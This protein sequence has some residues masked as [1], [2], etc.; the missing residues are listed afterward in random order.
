MVMPESSLIKTGISGLDSLFLGGIP[1]ANVILVQ[2]VTGCG[3]TLL[4]VEFVYRGILEYGEPGLI[5]VFETS[6]DKLI[7]DGAKFGWNLNEMQ[8]QKKLQIIF[9][10]PQ[11]FHQELRSSDSLLLETAAE[12][13]ARRIFVDGIGLLSTGL[14]NDDSLR[15]NFRGLLQQLMESFNRENLTAVISLETGVSAD[16]VA[17]TEM[18]DFLADTVIQLDRER[19][20]RRMRRSL[21]ILKSR[22]QD[23]DAGEHTLQIKTDHGLQI[24]RRVQAPLRGYLEQPTSGV[25][26][27]FT[28]VEAI[29]TL[30]GGGIF[31][32]S[33]TM[34]VGVSGVGKTVLGTQ[35]LREGRLQ[36]GIRGLLV[37]LDEHPAQIIRNAQTIGLN[38]EEQVADGS[39]QILF[40]SP[41]ELDVDAHYARITRLIEESDIQRMVL[42][43]MT[44]YSSAIGDIGVYRDF[45]HAIVAF[46][47]RR[48]M[49]TFF[50]Y[51]NPEFLGMSS[52]MPDFPVSSIVDNL[53]LMNMVEINNSLHR[54]IS[55]V[56]SRGSKHSFDT[57]EFVI[58]QGGISLIPLEQSLLPDLPLQNYSSLLGRAPTRLALPKVTNGAIA[59]R[60]K[61]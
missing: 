11:V 20:G 59:V 57:R 45:F 23:Y 38:L 7:R 26:R 16:L 49:T 14:V 33:T 12:M 19:I 53:I 60:G 36:Q 15:G 40:E 47:K 13:G 28:G 42:D 1:R 10:S 58:G 52:Y 34:V 25:K 24:F 3:K 8:Q 54:C 55:V 29:D 4:G 5:V 56:K 50:N 2:G 37:S 9:T 35:I 48:L 6:P 32:G 18:V 46:S 22:G 44:S 21:T 51:E 61:E 39:I 41:Q 43:G 31:D 27:A 30:I 17:T